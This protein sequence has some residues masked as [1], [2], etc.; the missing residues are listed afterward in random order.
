MITIDQ[1][2][3]KVIERIKAFPS[4][5]LFS[6]ADVGPKTTWDEYKENYQHEEYESFDYELYHE[7]INGMIEDEIDELSSEDIDLLYHSINESNHTTD[8]GDMHQEIEKV[9]FDCIHDKALSEEIEYQS[10]LNKYVKYWED[11]FS[12][13]GL[14][15]VAEVIKKVSPDEFLL[16]IYSRETPIEG[17][18]ENLSLIGLEQDCGL[19]GI[20]QEEFEEIKRGFYEEDKSSNGEIKS[21]D[22][23]NLETNHNRVTLYKF[24]SPKIE[25]LIQAYFEGENLMISDYSIGDNVEAY[26][27]DIDD[28]HYLTIRHDEVRKIYNALDL[29]DG[30]GNALL[31]ALEAKY[32]T[33]MCCTEFKAFLNDHEIKFE[34]DFW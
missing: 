11:D 2:A 22:A 8:R 23:I 3:N 34:E 26:S 16:Q 30:D 33:N 28:E 1:I 15:V 25:I 6:Q 21:E 18:P 19:V 13:D 32:N 12:E 29:K 9:I 27:G 31:T 5:A 7:T 24:K 14:L 20:T 10:P 4:E 17:K